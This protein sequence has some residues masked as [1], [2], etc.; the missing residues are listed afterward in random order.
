MALGVAAQ[1][2]KVDPK[3]TI[4]NNPQLARQLCGVIFG[5]TA[6]KAAQIQVLGGALVLAFIRCLPESLR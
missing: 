4:D 1:E 6:R 2:I 5:V 3:R